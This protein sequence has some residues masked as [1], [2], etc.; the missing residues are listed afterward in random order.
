MAS[1]YSD[2]PQFLATREGEAAQAQF[3][4]NDYGAV[5]D[6]RPYQIVFP[7]YPAPKFLQRYA[8]LDEALRECGT[9]CQLTGQP[10]RLMKWG[11]RLPC[12]PCRAHKSTNAL[13]SLKIMSPG[14]L[15]GYPGAQPIADFKPRSATIVYGPDGQ[16]KLVGGANFIVSRTPNPPEN[17]IDFK[18][19]LPQRYLEAV[20]TAQYLA[21]ATGQN[22]YL[23][24]STGASC[25]SRGKKGWVPVVYVDP[26]GLVK[27][28]PH[29]VQMPAGVHSIPGSSTVVN[30]MMTA[31]TF[32]E[33]IRE[34]EGRSRLG[35]GA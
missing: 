7:G 30:P 11:G 20:K 19:P 4:T 18:T 8:Y 10:F 16:P 29:D 34:S 14:A 13:P 5:G 24:S 32:R 1:E 15:H 28:Y 23:C 22:A 12:Y 35:Q 25:K 27:R 31:D 21:S 26:G 33:L 3:S 17:Y 2:T 9:L 6:Q